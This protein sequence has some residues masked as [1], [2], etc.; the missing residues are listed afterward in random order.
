MLL[1]RLM[2][3][4]F[5]CSDLWTELLK[6]TA[7]ENV[8]KNDKKSTLVQSIDLLLSTFHTLT[9]YKLLSDSLFTVTLIRDKVKGKGRFFDD[10]AFLLRIR[11]EVFTHV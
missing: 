10:L 1:T 3:L 7:G 6:E 11:G 9:N 4:H 8:E 5:F 2:G